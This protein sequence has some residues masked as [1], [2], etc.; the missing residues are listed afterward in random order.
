[1]RVLR[2][3]IVMTSIGA[4]LLAGCGGDDDGPGGGP[5]ASA[6]VSYDGA[7]GAPGT[8][9]GRQDASADAAG[10]PDAAIDRATDVAVDA[11]DANDAGGADTADGGISDAPDAPT[12]DAA[13]D[14][15]DAAADLG[16]ADGAIADGADGAGAADAGDAGPDAPGDAVTPLEIVTG[17]T[18]GAYVV[19]A[20]ALTGAPP[21]SYTFNVASATAGTVWLRRD[22]TPVRS[23]NYNW[24]TTVS[25]SDPGMY[26]T[27]DFAGYL[28]VTIRKAGSGTTNLYEM[29][30]SIFNSAHYL[31]VAPGADGSTADGGTI[32]ITAGGTYTP[33]AVESIVLGGAPSGA[34][35][36][37]VTSPTAG[38]VEL[39]RDGAPV[40]TLVYN[41]QTTVSATD[42]GMF[43][44]FN[45][46]GYFNITVRKAGSGTINL[47]AMDQSIF[48][49]MHVL[50]VLNDGGAGGD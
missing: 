9:A 45:F 10:N 16:S 49:G 47:Y 3:F 43:H 5:D 18:Y 23:V 22:G 25:A 42:P 15:A 36:F 29:D 4:G 38:S 50:T 46:A 24:Q 32:P 19:H 8:D 33:Y 2:R 41:W 17:G 31:L 26:V 37:H 34:Y 12:S 35:T 21:G 6:D 44:S 39:R 48:S 14:A 40:T 28:S 1:M 30:Q 27:F 11:R 20:T 7:G 13:L